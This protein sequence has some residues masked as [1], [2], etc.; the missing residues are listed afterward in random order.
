MN[1]PTPLRDDP[2]AP[3][4]LLDM[5]EAAKQVH[6]TVAERAALGA[7][8]GIG[9]G[10]FAVPVA[11]WLVGSALVV[12]GGLAFVTGQTEPTGAP[13][14]TV[15]SAPIEKRPAVPQ[16]IQPSGVSVDAPKPSATEESEPPRSRPQAMVESGKAEE[17]R[18][19]VAPKTA[20]ATSAQPSEA[21][22]LSAARGLVGKD[23]KRALRILAQHESLYPRGILSQEREVLRVRALKESGQ[24]SSAE[25][26]AEEFRKNHPD[27]AHTTHL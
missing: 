23:P 7:K 6:P 20:A 27:S 9:S 10:L 12:G 26:Q 19:K 17:S 1:E 8:L 25:R 5:F 16:P 18:P 2:D 13:Q 4:A 11:K 3:Q 22:L 24:V 14:P 15:Q 21:Q